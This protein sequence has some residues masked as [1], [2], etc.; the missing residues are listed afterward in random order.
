MRSQVVNIVL[1]SGLFSGLLCGLCAP[2][3]ANTSTAALSVGH[4][5]LAQAAETVPKAAPAGAADP[6]LSTVPIAPKTYIALL[7]PLLS[8]SLGPASEAIR[9]G[10]LAAYDRESD[11]VVVNVIETGDASADIL[12]SYA[13]ALRTNDMI[14]GPLSRA[15][16]TAL[17]QSATLNKPTIALNQPEPRDAEGGQDA[18][19]PEN[20][21]VMGLSVEDEARQVAR[22]AAADKPLGKAFVLSTGQGWQRRAAKAF[23]AQWQHDGL[24]AQS[25]E[26]SV[27]SGYL[28]ASGMAQLRARMQTEKPALLFVALDGAQTR[29]VR[30]TIGHELPIYG[31][32]QVNG[33]ILQ[34]QD[35]ESVLRMDGVRLLDLPWQLQT[36]HPAV[37][38]YPHLVHAVDQKPNADLE[39]LYA[40][41]IDAYRVAR[42]IALKHAT[43]FAIDGVTGKLTVSFGNG[44]AHFERQ[45]MPAIYR[46]GLLEPLNSPAYP[47]APPNPINPP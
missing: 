9:A 15:A 26:I 10:F 36:D 38:V 3:R 6:R 25:V 47:I 45:E 28:S 39:R 32:S 40:L 14:V 12:G 30:D 17:A 46:G 21:L 33:A 27:S 8:D 29:Q 11:Q 37:M 4:A 19:L 13:T 24:V 42:E 5:V 1:F 31:T 18:P 2:S 22:W 7:L 43:Q 16:V 34:A 44:V 23:V 20:M 35:A 41:G